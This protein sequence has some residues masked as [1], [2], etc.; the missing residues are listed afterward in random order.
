[1]LQYDATED[2][3]RSRDREYVRT[4]IPAG[5]LT[6]VRIEVQRQGQYTDAD[7]VQTTRTGIKQIPIQLTV[8]G[9]QYDGVV[10]WDKIT[11]PEALQDA[12]GWTDGQR[13]S[14]AIGAETI[15]KILAASKKPLNARL[16]DDLDD[17]R[18]PVKIGVEQLDRGP[19]NRVQAWLDPGS[20]HDKIA[21]KIAQMGQQD[22]ARQPIQVGTA[23][24]PAEG[25]APVPRPQPRP[26][27]QPQPKYDGAYGQAF[28]RTVD[29]DEP[30][31]DI[32]F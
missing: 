29:R 26:Q 27:P 19:A 11:L 16:P 1:M 6:W 23:P 31:D 12:C 30:A 2:L 17:C 15:G 8:I 10:F 3:Q 9:P 20:P 24:V 5:S 7:G 22:I 14:F 13:K 18:A 32:P 25:A 28:G 21:A 4:V